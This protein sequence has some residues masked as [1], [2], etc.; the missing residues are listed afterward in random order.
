MRRKVGRGP[1]R[2]LDGAD[3]GRQTEYLRPSALGAMHMATPPGESKK[4]Q[5][6]KSA[7]HEGKKVRAAPSGPAVT[8]GATPRT[9][10]LP[11]GESKGRFPAPAAKPAK[12]PTKGPGGGSGQ[13]K[14]KA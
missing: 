4:G 5:A 2:A 12:S 13:A 3:D 9:T 14:G 1:M 8:G 11:P 6:S 10:D 7:I